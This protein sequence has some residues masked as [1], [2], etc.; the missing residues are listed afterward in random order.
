M[1]ES[2]EPEIPFQRIYRVTSKDLC[3]STSQSFY[4]NMRLARA[5]DAKI[6]ERLGA[7]ANDFYSLNHA[8][9]HG[10]ASPFLVK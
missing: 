4:S 7:I 5:K 9:W 2:R 10:K 6:S 3:I 8:C 1:H